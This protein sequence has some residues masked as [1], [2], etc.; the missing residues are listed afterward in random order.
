LIVLFSPNPK[1]DR[2]SGKKT[3]VQKK[4]KHPKLQ[5]QYSSIHLDHLTRVDGGAE[6]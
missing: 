2:G 5:V 4:K 3:D 1:H 6:L